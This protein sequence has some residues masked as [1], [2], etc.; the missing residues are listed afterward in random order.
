MDLM[1]QFQE[2]RRF[3][4]RIQIVF[5]K[6]APSRESKPAAI[7]PKMMRRH[8]PEMQTKL[9]DFPRFTRGTVSL[10]RAGISASG[11]RITYST[12]WLDIAETEIGLVSAPVSE[13]CYWA[14]NELARKDD[15]CR[16]NVSPR[17]GRFANSTGKRCE[18]RPLASCRFG[19]GLWRA[20]KSIECSAT[21]ASW[22]LIRIACT[23]TQVQRKTPTIET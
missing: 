8:H 21:K 2:K 13:P 17:F 9:W 12:Q 11:I 18:R 4:S 10:V 16:N 23:A 22:Y 15:P 19:P 1:V 14:R 20:S 5:L 6:N 7:C 3:L